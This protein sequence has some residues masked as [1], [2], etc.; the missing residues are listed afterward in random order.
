MGVVSVFLALG[1][2]PSHH[3]YSHRGIH[4]APIASGLLHW[5]TNNR[6]GLECQQG[7]T[8][9]EKSVQMIYFSP[10]LELTKPL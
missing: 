2:A 9:K 10:L 4:S 7:T 1:K 6:S 5:Q 8:E 3:L